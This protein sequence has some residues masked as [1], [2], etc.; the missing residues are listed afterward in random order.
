MATLDELAAELELSRGQVQAILAEAQ[1]EPTG[2]FAD[3]VEAMP[4]LT[5]VASRG[6][7]SK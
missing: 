4:R 6:I 5:V 2:G 3:K 1:G 7:S